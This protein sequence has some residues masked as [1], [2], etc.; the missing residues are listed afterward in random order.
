MKKIKRWLP[1]SLC[2]KL[3][4]EEFKDVERVWRRDVVSWYVEKREKTLGGKFVHPIF[5]NR[6]PCPTFEELLA[7]VLS[8]PEISFSLSH[9]TLGFTV[10]LD[11]SKR[12]LMCCGIGITPIE[13]LCMAYLEDEKEG[14]LHDK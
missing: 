6:Y 13:A 9:D 1:V 5:Y 3:S 7:V 8:K 12:H 11:D 14:R 10:T 2:K 4:K